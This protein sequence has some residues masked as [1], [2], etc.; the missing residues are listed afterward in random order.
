MY[1]FLIFHKYSVYSAI[2]FI[3]GLLC[4][5]IIF[6]LPEQCKNVFH[7]IDEI[8]IILMTEKHLYIWICHL[9]NRKR[10]LILTEL[11]IFKMIWFLFLFIYG[12]LANNGNTILR[13]LGEKEYSLIKGKKLKRK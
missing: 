8:H 5:V 6:R 13:D 11:Y 3:F 4:A 10:L 9:N 7:T 2:N 12:I 1:K